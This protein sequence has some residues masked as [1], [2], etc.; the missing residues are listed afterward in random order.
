MACSLNLFHA[1]D[2]TVPRDHNEREE[3]ILRYV[4]DAHALINVVCSKRKGNMMSETKK[5][6]AE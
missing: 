4:S 2:E 6:M 5:G 1:R 3:E